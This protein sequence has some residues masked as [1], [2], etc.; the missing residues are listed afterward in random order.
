[1]NS[2]SHLIDI[3]ESSQVGEA[4]RLA[5]VFADRVQLSEDDRGKVALITTELGT[6]LVKHAKQGYLLL[7]ILG[8]GEGEGEGVEVLSVD[9]GPGITHVGQAL[10]D[11]FSTAGTRGQGLGAISRKA[12]E[13][14]LSTDH[15]GTVVLARFWC[16]GFKPAQRLMETGGVCVRLKTERVCGD[17]WVVTQD[18][19]RVVMMVVDGLGHG[20]LA[21]DAALEAAQ[22]FNRTATGAIVDTLHAMHAQLKA[23]RG[24][25]GAV[26]EIIPGTQRLSYAGIGNIAGS[27]ITGGRR[28]SLVSQN[29]TLGAQMRPPTVFDYPFA[30]DAVA[31]LASDGISTQWD[32]KDYPGLLNRHPAVI[33]AVIHRDFARGRD[34]ATVLVARR[35][36]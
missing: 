2:E 21:A 23:T 26:C 18:K 32:L 35:P 4:R 10:R 30:E 27:I 6:N 16:E 15:R 14:D 9:R 7:R 36:L 24:A 20:Q 33:A 28:V 1:M 13:F 11:G 31:I 34:D 25:A 5:N 29:G 17:G 8:D 22:A 3:V 19:G 12:H